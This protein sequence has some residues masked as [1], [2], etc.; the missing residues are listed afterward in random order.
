MAEE[1]CRVDPGI[2]RAQTPEMLCVG[3]WGLVGG[4]NRLDVL[5]EIC[6]HLTPRERRAMRE[7]LDADDEWR[8][9]DD[10]DDD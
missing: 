9:Q 8:W 10:D 3:Y 6:A 4:E 7:M 1:H 5:R 2:W